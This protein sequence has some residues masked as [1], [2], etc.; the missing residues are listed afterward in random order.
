MS[1]LSRIITLTTDFGSQDYYVSAMK[2]VM[3]QIYPEVRIVDISHDLPPQDIMAGAWVLKNTAF[4]YPAGTI[5]L[6]VI[7][8]GVGSNRRP[9]LVKVRDQFFVGPDNGLFS[10]V[11]EENKPRVVELM[12]QKYWRNIISTTFHGRD[13]FAPVAAHL[14]KGEPM[15]AF[16]VERSDLT[17]YRWAKP[18]SD[19]KGIQGWVMHIDRYGNLVTNI[20][21]TLIKEHKNSPAFKI[22]VGNTILKTI[23]GSFSDVPDGEAVALIGS[24]GMLE[25]A[26]NKGNAERMLGIEKG[27]PVSL[28]IQKN[29][30]FKR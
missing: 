21:E 14:C 5:H 16:G 28:I 17:T 4:L 20:P 11:S 3:L 6:A 18:I 23:A 7:D 24:S 19:D 12:N 10:L 30:S 2:A 27:A 15:E 29:V 1:T 9:V 8:P 25:I 13:I 26:I 22:Y